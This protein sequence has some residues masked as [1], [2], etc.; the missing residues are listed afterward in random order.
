LYRRIGTA[1]DHDDLARV[2]AEAED[3]FGRLP[4]PAL[5]LLAVASLRLACLRLGVDEVTTFRN[6]VRVKPVDDAWG[7]GVAA[8]MD[9]ASYRPATR[10]LNLEPPSTLGGEELARWVEGTLAGAPAA[11]ARTERRAPT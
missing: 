11:D 6:Q 3:R 9:G 2:R 1:R 8:T 7:H 4:P 5:T 10:T